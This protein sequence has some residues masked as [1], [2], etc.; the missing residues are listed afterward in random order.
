MEPRIDEMVLMVQR[1][2][3]TTYG[4]DSRFNKVEENGKTGWNTIYGLRRALQIEIGIQETSDSFGPS[5]YAKCPNI[6]QGDEGNLVYIVQGGLWCKGY[7]PGGF[8]GYYGNGTYAAVKQLK[9]DMGFPTASGN[10]NRDIMK[11][12]LDMS[13]FVCL[14]SQGGTEEIRSIQQKLNYDYYDYYQICPCD[15]LYNRE[16][17][18]MLIYALQKELG[19]AKDDATGTWGPTT[20]SLCKA[21]TYSIG[22]LNNIIKLIRYATVCNGFSVK[23]NTNIYDRELE[24]VLDKFSESLLIPKASGEIDYTVIKSLLSSNGDVDRPA[25][26][27]DT[28]TQLNLKQIKTIKEAGYEVVGRYL[29]NTPGGTLNKRLTIEEIN[30]INNEGLNIFP[31]FQEVGRSVEAFNVTTGRENGLKAYNATQELNIPVGTTIYFAVDFD[32]TDDEITEGI[33]PYFKGIKESEINNDYI[34]GVY[35]TRNVCSRLRKEASIRRFFVLDASYGFSGNLGFTMPSNWC[36]DQFCTD[37]EIGTGEGKVA[38]DKVAVSGIDKGFSGESSKTFEVYTIISRLYDLARNYTNGDINKSNLLVT[39][40]LR[41]RNGRYNDDIWDL[42][43]GALDTNFESLANEQVKNSDNLSFI[44][45]VK[46][47]EYDF[48]HFMASLNAVFYLSEIPGFDLNWEVFDPLVDIFATWG[49]D[50]T[51]YSEDV[52]LKG[53]DD[54]ELYANTMICRKENTSSTFSLVDYLTDIDALLFGYLFSEKSVADMFYDYFIEDNSLLARSRTRLYV[55]NAYGDLET[56]ANAVR[57]FQDGLF[58]NLPQFM[59]PMNYLKVKITSS[60][61]VPELKY[62]RAAA[63]A[64]INFVTEEF[65]N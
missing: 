12:L 11:G 20:T 8:N 45:P 54:Y 47:I 14:A 64:F 38:I 3:N 41:Q 25:K 32:P 28:A 10:M 42:T 17:N 33:I 37:I 56:F 40:Y 57:T 1:W 13:A 63:E 4:D 39:Q 60:G 48:D 52:Q 16:M 53:G 61:E 30:N 5:T 31:I 55:R 23:I 27:C 59:D 7:S 34:I 35:G 58:P 43:G 24:L 62:R 46:G 49:G 51:T 26:G 2:L 36:F 65:N 22:D 19:I 18:K 50:L 9:S 15:G 6:N 21:K 29:T 44:D